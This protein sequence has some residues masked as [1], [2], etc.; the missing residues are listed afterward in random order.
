MVKQNTSETRDS[1]LTWNETR[2][3]LEF[4]C[5]TTIV[6]CPFLYWINGAAVSYDQL[7]VR[8]ALMLLAIFGA[9]GF[10]LAALRRRMRNGPG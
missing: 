5:W 4:A 7:V 6:L 8:T 10:R 9:I 1:E 2:G 3:W